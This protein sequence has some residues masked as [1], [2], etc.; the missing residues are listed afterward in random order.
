MRDPPILLTERLTLRAHRPSDFDDCAAMW[1]DPAVTRY[2]G[3]RPF[4]Q[5]EVW[6]K[7]LRY[8]GHWSVLGF[9]YWVAR[10]KGS[11]RFVGEVGFADFKRDIQPSLGGIPEIGWALS[12]WAYGRG[13]ATESVRAVVAWWDAEF[14]PARTACLIA[15]GNTASIR[16][17]EKCGYS[18]L[19]RT[20][21]RGL[22]IL[23]FGRG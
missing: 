14:G 5:E 21:Y 19:H 12:P 6:T 1:A 22:P 23:I 18:E 13:L 2:I 3:G 10:E 9:G 20:T 17:A 4:S 7:L 11:E 15:P 16:V 8:A